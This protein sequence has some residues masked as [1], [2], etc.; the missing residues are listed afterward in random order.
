MRIFSH[1]LQ[2]LLLGKK[3]PRNP[4]NSQNHLLGKNLPQISQRIFT[5][6]LGAL[7]SQRIEFTDANFRGCT[8]LKCTNVV[9]GI[10][11]LLGWCT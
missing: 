7:I 6:S 9:R 2:M 8:C 4:R 11:T 10:S 3:L 5:D 1:R